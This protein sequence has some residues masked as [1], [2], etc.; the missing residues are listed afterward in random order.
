MDVYIP[1]LVP[2]TFNCKIKLTIRC[3]MLSLV[4]YSFSY[5]L[6]IN[7]IVMYLYTQIEEHFIFEYRI[8][9]YCVGQFISQFAS[10]YFQS[11][12]NYPLA[13]PTDAM[14]LQ[15]IIMTRLTQKV[16]RIVTILWFF[17]FVGFLRWSRVELDASDG[18]ITPRNRII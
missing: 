12:W 9:S 11:F 18:L 3:Y 2:Y 17:R 16:A 10:M 14:I 7:C 6:P 4:D 8:S 1:Y 13:N 5:Y 15:L